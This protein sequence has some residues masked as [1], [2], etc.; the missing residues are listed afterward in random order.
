[1]QIIF[2]C[3]VALNDKEAQNIHVIELYNNLS[4]VADVMSFRAK[5]QKN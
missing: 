4:K 3:D 2:T 1:M 5:T